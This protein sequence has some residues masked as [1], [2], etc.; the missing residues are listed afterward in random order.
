MYAT[1][2]ARPWHYIFDCF[3]NCFNLF[4]YF[5]L[6]YNM[7]D[8]YGFMQYFL[9][10]L[11][12]LPFG[13]VWCVYLDCFIIFAWC[14]RLLDCICMKSMILVILC[15]FAI[16]ISCISAGSNIED[17]QHPWCHEKTFL[18]EYCMHVI[19][20]LRL[21]MQKSTMIFQLS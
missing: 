21:G 5:H 8:D 2:I 3:L 7:W 16:W 13:W 10:M 14:T 4:V 9:Q 18:P 20:E 6:A 19:V 12:S 1:K 15:L 11:W 17:V